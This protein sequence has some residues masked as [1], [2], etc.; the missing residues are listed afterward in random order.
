VARR[1]RNAHSLR[2]KPGGQAPREITLII[3]E[4]ESDRMYFDALRNHLRLS[5]AEVSFPCPQGSAPINIVNCA[6]RKAREP[7]RYDYIYCVFDR[8]AH[9]TFADARAKL[10]LHA[11]HAPLN[12]AIS[13]PCF[14]VWLLLHFE[15][16]DAPFADCE[17]VIRRLVQHLP[18][19]TKNDPRQLP[20][21]LERLE[22]A[23]QHAQRIE[24]QWTT[25]GD[26]PYT[27]V[28]HLVRH[29]QDIAA[30]DPRA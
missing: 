1:T 7:G 6:I 30:K 18:D 24:S 22:Q 4:G 29:L 14:E 12:E 5:N 23:M 25:I 21:L 11:K 17:D 2:R 15:F 10:R 26:N 19:Y 16:T 9:S 3:C 28:H 20:P 27:S 13:I 8:D